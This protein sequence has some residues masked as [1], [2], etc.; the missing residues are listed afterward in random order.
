M[1]QQLQRIGIVILLLGLINGCTYFRDPCKT[2]GSVYT[3]AR[4]QPV[5]EAPTG[6]SVPEPDPNLT[7]PET[8]G[9]NVPFSR[10]VED[11]RRP[12]KQRVQCLS[13]PPPFRGG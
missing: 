9:I 4:E 12:G 5:L 3:E 10:T 7:I 6:L 2:P 8:A 1:K 13:E 11:E